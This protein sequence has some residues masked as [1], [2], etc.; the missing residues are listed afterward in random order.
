MARK[1][2]KRL[3]VGQLDVPEITFHLLTDIPIASADERFALV[4]WE[5]A[6]R[7]VRSG[8]AVSLA[9]KASDVAAARRYADDELSADPNDADTRYG[10]EFRYDASTGRLWAWR[11][12]YSPFNAEAGEL[13][14]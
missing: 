2:S 5:S 12:M 8:M 3:T 13:V 1:Q 14:G 6:C 11:S 7:E 10:V 9:V 4:D